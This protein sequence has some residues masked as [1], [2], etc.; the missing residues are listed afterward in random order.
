[1]DWSPAPIRGQNPYS[2]ALILSQR[3]PSQPRWLRSFTRS[4]HT[5]AQLGTQTQTFSL[6]LAWA[7]LRLTER[8]RLHF[9]AGARFVLSLIA[10]KRA[11]VLSSSGRL[12]QTKLGKVGEVMTGRRILRRRKNLNFCMCRTRFLGE[13]FLESISE[14][15]GNDFF[16]L[17]SKTG[18]IWYFFGGKCLK[19]A[20]ISCLIFHFLPHFQDQK[21]PNFT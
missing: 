7:C 21:D 12:V 13:E 3:Q 5:A 9:F 2:P 17:S 4:W 18:I 8:A 10:W 6:N 15:W 20:K 1:M 16:Q 14:F 11:P 19:I